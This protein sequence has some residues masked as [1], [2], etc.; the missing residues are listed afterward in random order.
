[1]GHS[2]GISVKE[3]DEVIVFSNENDFIQVVSA[4]PQMTAIIGADEYTRNHHPG[5]FMAGIKA[6]QQPDT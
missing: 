2:Y 1:M 4:N 6:I 5:V 3:F